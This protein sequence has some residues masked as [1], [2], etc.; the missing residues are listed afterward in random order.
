MVGKTVRRLAVPIF[1]LAA[2]A[3]A[4]AV[5]VAAD[6]GDHGQGGQHGQHG[7]RGR[8]HA[9]VYFMTATGPVLQDGAFGIQHRRDG[10]ISFSVHA[11]ALLPGT[12]P[13]VFAALYNDPQSCK[14][15]GE[16]IAICSGGSDN[17]HLTV[18]LAAGRVNEDGRLVVRGRLDGRNGLTN[19]AGAEVQVV[20]LDFPTAGGAPTVEFGVLDPSSN[21]DSDSNPD[22]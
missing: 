3:A 2:L 4:T 19:A 21:P 10:S 1:G 15:S 18:P 11:N 17:P 22:N 14:V 8:N 16:P 9:P 13:M 5:P 12:T 20:I 7:E 6:G